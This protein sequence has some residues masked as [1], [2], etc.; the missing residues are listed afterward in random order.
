ML[1]KVLTL[2][3]LRK[4]GWNDLKVAESI[5]ALIK[6]EDPALMIKDDFI[7]QLLMQFKNPNNY[8]FLL[9]DETLKS[10]GGFIS[11]RPLEKELFER[12]KKGN[13]DYRETN[14]HIAEL[15]GEVHLYIGGVTISDKYRKNIGN[16]RRILTAIFDYFSML[17]KENIIVKDVATR[18]LTEDGK[19]LCMGLGLKYMAEHKEEGKIFGITFNDPSS[20]Q[21]S[22][23][24]YLAGMKNDRV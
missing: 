11:I 19:R 2:P 3:E 18:A 24:R 5:D 16:F 1:G 10:I 13:F 12:I 23:I 17:V 22:L 15:K 14:E 21:A 7:A 20:K 6:A 8:L 4:L 9:Y